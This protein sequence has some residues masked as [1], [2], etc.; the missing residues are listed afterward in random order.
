MR[1]FLFVSK[2]LVQTRFLS[3]HPTITEKAASVFT[4]Y[5]LSLTQKSNVTKSQ[6][7]KTISFEI[8]Q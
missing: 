5:L 1:A 3:S 6:F 8:V 7:L 2:S 4:Q